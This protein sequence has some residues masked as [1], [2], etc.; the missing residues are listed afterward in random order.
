MSSVVLVLELSA[1][2]LQLAA[3]TMS[4]RHEFQMQLLRRPF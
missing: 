4:E 1:H 2:K 3:S